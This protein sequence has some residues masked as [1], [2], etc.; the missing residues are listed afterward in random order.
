MRFDKKSVSVNTVIHWRKEEKQQMGKFIKIVFPT[1]ED[2]TCYW[3]LDERKFFSS[4]IPLGRNRPLGKSKG[5]SAKGNKILERLA[6][7]YP[8]K[9]NADDLAEAFGVSRETIHNYISIIRE[10]SPVLKK[11]I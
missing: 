6:D 8:G 1:E 3:D 7:V 5:V 2:E 9:L 4:D 11:N 10:I